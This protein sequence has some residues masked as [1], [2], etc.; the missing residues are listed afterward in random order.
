MG[1]VH[2]LVPQEDYDVPSASD[3]EPLAQFQGLAGDRAAETLR[4]SRMHLA[5]GNQLLRV[6]FPCLYAVP[7]S[8]PSSVSRISK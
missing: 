3:G 5:A 4:S 2:H 7:V 1:V 8:S 6:S